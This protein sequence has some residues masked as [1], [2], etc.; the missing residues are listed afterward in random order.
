[1]W[2]YVSDRYEGPRD[3]VS[4]R[5]LESLLARIQDLTLRHRQPYLMESLALSELEVWIPGE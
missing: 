3:A 5:S 1:M 2:G 4:G